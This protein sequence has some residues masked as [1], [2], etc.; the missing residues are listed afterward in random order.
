[1]LSRYKIFRGRR[2]PDDPLPAGVRVD[3]RWRTKHPL[4]PTEEM[5]REFL[6][7]AKDRAAW[8]K[9][10]KFYLDLLEERFRE[11]RAVFDELAAKAREGD[12]FLG[13][14]CPTNLNPRV[15]HCHTYLAL[16]FMKRKY[17]LLV[18]K[19]PSE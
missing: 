7:S 8:T 13:C 18:V 9:F 4:R 6:E 12:V 14:N 2:P 3:T 10:K 19:L 16:Q 11:D 15:E 5:A 1:M 17:R